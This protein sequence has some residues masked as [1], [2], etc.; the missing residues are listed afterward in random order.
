MKTLG[1]CT[2]FS[3]FVTEYNAYMKKKI[4]IS[5]T[6]DDSTDE[7]HITIPRTELQYVASLIRR[8]CGG[9]MAIKRDKTI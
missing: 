1:D 2:I 4:N 6:Y 9:G 7:L 5:I 8:R 3:N